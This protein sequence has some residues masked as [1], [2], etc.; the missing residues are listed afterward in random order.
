MKGRAAFEVTMSTR[1]CGRRQLA[2]SNTV[3]QYAVAVLKDDTIVGHLLKTS[4]CIYS[5]FLRRGGV[6]QCRVAGRRKYLD[7]PQGI[8]FS[9]DKI[10]PP[11]V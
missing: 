7:L 5:L 1:T 6:I 2:K 11:Q 10:S 9:P 4:A 8:K 3:N